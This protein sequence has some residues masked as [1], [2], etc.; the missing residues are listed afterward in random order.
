MSSRSSSITPK[1]LVFQ[2]FT[3]GANANIFALNMVRPRVPFKKTHSF[4]H[5]WS[6][7]GSLQTEI[8]YLESPARILIFW[9][10]TDMNQIFQ[11]RYYE[12]LQ[13]K[14][15]QS[16]KPSNFTKTKDGPPASLDQSDFS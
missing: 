10:Q 16:Y 6:K 7:M 13:I 14:G 11:M 15:L 5:L 1:L 8:E 4:G 9:F 12:A 2:G 3:D